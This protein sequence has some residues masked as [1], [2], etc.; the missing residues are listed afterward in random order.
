MT[1]NY[2]NIRRDNGTG[3]RSGFW[4]GNPSKIDN[5]HR[6]LCSLG[7]LYFGPHGNGWFV[8]LRFPITSY[9]IAK[10]SIYI[11][12]YRKYSFLV[13][14]IVPR[15]PIFISMMWLILVITDRPI[16]GGRYCGF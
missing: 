7:D 16:D 4:V 2:K 9:Y 13:I 15:G 1:I 6:C 5:S 10:Y 11:Y 3:W 12:I 8:L 14:S